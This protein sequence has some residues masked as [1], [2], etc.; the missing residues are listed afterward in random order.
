[1]KNFKGTFTA[2]I[3]PFKN[4][5]V[6]YASLDRLLKQQL[7]GGVDG[8][9][10]NGT[11]A[12][13]P[14]LSTQE[15]AELFKHIRKFVGDKVPLIMGT[16]SNDTAKSIETSRKAEE[17][18]ADAILVVVPYYNKP[19]QRGLFEHFKAVASSVKIPTLLYNVPGRTI[20]S[21]ATETIRDLAKVPG[22]IGIKEATGKID[23]AQ[24]IIKA[25]GKDFVMLSGDDGTY[26]DFLGAGGHGVISVATH[27]IP[28]QMVQWK[29]WVSEGQIEKARADINKYM[30]LINLLF[31]EANP[32]P[33]KKALQLMGVI[34]S[35]SLRLPLVELTPEHT[36][37]LK[38]EMK[39]VGLL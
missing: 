7:D 33:V 29:K 37:S 9:V 34:D 5:K 6:D 1:M 4:D 20:T 14:T 18:G 10:V 38:A 25:C 22:V 21:L 28:A 12:E 13:S 2:L 15:V 16:G 32:I 39:K 35:A 11:T 27:V 36:E 3:T 30:N 19:P 26:V 23:L 8:F 17:M 24:D 31:V